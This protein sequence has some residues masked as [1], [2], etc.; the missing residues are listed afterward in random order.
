M[1]EAIK[2][3]AYRAWRVAR[4]ALLVAGVILLV[5]A[6]QSASSRAGCD[7]RTA[8]CCDQPAD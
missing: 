8:L 7:G 1:T 3:A 4:V 2:Y 5:S 6:P